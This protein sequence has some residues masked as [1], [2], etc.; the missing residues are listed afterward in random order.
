MGMELDKCHKCDGIWFD[1]G[2][3]D[4]LRDAKVPEIEELIEQKYGDPAFQ[5]GEPEG[6]MRCPRCVH[7]PLRSQT[8]TY[9]HPVRIDVCSTCYGIWLDDTELDAIIGE[10][11]KWEAEEGRFKSF[12]RKVADHL[13]GK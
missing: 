8:Y 11:E 2:E 7:A 9:E 12:L 6:Y 13:K 5:E 1:R 4:R 10:K 3:L